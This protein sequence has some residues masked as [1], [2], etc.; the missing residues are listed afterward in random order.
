MQDYETMG[1]NVDE[2][3]RYAEEDRLKQEAEALA[4]QTGAASQAPGI[5]KTK[6]VKTTAD[7]QEALLAKM[8]SI[9]DTQK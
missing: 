6:A 7:E 3:A 2:A 5:N 1:Y 9:N 8:L 4:N